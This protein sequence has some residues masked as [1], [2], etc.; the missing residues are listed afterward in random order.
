MFAVPEKITGLNNPH[1]EN[2][3]VKKTYDARF[4]EDKN[5]LILETYNYDDTPRLASANYNDV[6]LHLD[7]L[8]AQASLKC[9][10]IDDVQIRSTQSAMVH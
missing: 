7:D 3:Y 5:I 1:I 4:R 8:K 10:R 6:V 9:G 2:A